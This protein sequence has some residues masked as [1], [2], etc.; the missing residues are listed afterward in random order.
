M[1]VLEMARGGV[2]IAGVVSVHG[3]LE[4]PHPAEPSAMKA[5]VLVCH[6]ALDPHVPPAHVAAF[7]EEMNRAA[8]DWELIAYGGAMHGFTH[9]DAAR[10]PQPGVAYDRRA[11]ERSWAAIERFLAEI[12]AGA[13]SG[14]GRPA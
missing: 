7:M 11:D 12:F 5:R 10:R 3:S 8:A 13:A 2:E 6:G 4:T 1:I 14:A 9:E